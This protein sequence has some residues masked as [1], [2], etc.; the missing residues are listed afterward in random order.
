[1]AIRREEG[2]PFSFPGGPSFVWEAAD[3]RIVAG[4]LE[5]AARS[6]HADREIFNVT[7]GDVFEWRNLWPSFAETLGVEVGPDEPASLATYLRERSRVW[8]KVVA[9]HGL[10]PLSL[11]QLV[12]TA[13][14]HADFSFAY[15]ASAGPRAFSSTVK[16]RNAGF[17][18]AMHTAE[19][20]RDAFQ[21]LIDRN[22]LP[23]AL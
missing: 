10:E 22:V 9:R 2:L 18:E 14:H 1:V 11:E 12:G 5:W 19:S 13:D 17:C 3:A 21:A 23:A 6:P 16:L 4:V 8:D 15:G 7:N 20:F